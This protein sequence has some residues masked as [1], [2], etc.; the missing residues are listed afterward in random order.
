[1]AM[2]L[3]RN[4]KVRA[5][6]KQIMGVAPAGSVPIRGNH[7]ALEQMLG[8]VRRWLRLLGRS[9]STLQDMT[10][11]LRELSEEGISISREM[12]AALSPYLTR[13][14]KRFGDYTLDMTIP[15]QPFQGDLPLLR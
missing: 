3:S 7:V 14:I 6:R 1:M 12:V 5:S 15:P 11:V 4:A 8:N 13:N 9:F 2:R 10:Q